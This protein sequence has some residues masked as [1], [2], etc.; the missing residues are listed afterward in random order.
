MHKLSRGNHKHVFLTCPCFIFLTDNP[1]L[2]HPSMPPDLTATAGTIRGPLYTLQQ[3][4]LDSPHKIPM[5]TSPLLDPMPTLKI[6]VYNSST[7]SSLELP[8]SGGCGGCG[9]G[10]DGEIMSLKTVGTMGGIRGGGEQHGHTLPRE[11][12][13]SASATLGCLGGRLT[14]PNTGEERG[15]CHAEHL[16]THKFNCH[17]LL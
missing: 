11:P 9:D 12:G 5:T 2:L 6:K 17:V 14:I 15:R 13:H 16:V 8:S 4:T 7:M 10:S 1:H 3:S